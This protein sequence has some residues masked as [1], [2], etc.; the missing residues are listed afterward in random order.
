[1]SHIAMDLSP[2]NSGSCSATSNFTTSST[3]PVQSESLEVPSLSY[4]NKDNIFSNEITVHFIYDELQFP[5]KIQASDFK[6]FYTKVVFVLSNKKSKS[7]PCHLQYQV[8]TKWY[9]FNENIGFDDL[10]MDAKN[11]EIFI[12][13][14]SSLLDSAESSGT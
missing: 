7:E 11:P 14:I 3:T 9:D 6:E 4:N 10:C 5:K 13:A 12:K 1:M 2:S 8:G